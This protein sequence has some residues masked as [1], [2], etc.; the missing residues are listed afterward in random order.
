V[1]IQVIFRHPDRLGDDF[2]G[3]AVLLPSDPLNALNQCRVGNFYN[4]PAPFL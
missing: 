2:Y 3:L 1:R 4:H